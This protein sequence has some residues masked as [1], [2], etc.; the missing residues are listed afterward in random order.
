LI[1]CFIFKP[2]L[3]MTL[4]INTIESIGELE[5]NRKLI[6]I[7]AP[8]I[9]DVTMVGHLYYHNRTVKPMFSLRRYIGIQLQLP[10]PLFSRIGWSN[11]LISSVIGFIHNKTCHIFCLLLYYY[12]LCKCIHLLIASILLV[13]SFPCGCSFTLKLWLR[14]TGS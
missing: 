13:S 1:I 5:P 4:P 7:H 14:I 10:F 2:L 11:F 6:L 12:I 3:S 9:L 8:F